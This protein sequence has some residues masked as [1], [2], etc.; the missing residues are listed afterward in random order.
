M[1]RQVYSLEGSLVA[2]DNIALVK[3]EN[4]FNYSAAS[5]AAGIYVIRVTEGGR[6]HITKL[7]VVK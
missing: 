7:S 3:G 4:V 5:L 1:V 6:Q 2:E